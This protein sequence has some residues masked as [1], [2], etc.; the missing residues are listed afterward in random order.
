LFDILEKAE[1]GS[2][3]YTAVQIQLIYDGYT[4]KDAPQLCRV[5]ELGFPSLMLNRNGA[6]YGIAT[7]EAAISQY[8]ESIAKNVLDQMK[9]IF[10]GEQADTLGRLERLLHWRFGNDTPS[11]ED[12]SGPMAEFLQYLDLYY[13]GMQHHQ[14]GDFELA[15]TNYYNALKTAPHPDYELIA[16]QYRL[17]SQ[18]RKR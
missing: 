13:Y 1:P 14:K 16:E 11:D 18:N 10:G 2:P 7:V 6:K 17:L 5:A 3:F 4:R 15:K 8:K 9:A 12:T